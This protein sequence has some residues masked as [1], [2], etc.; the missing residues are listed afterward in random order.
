MVSS[1]KQLMSEERANMFR[2]MATGASKLGNFYVADIYITTCLKASRG[3]KPFPVIASLVKLFYLK[4]ACAEGV[5][6][7]ANKFC[8]ALKFIASKRDEESIAHVP[9]NL[10]R[11]RLLEGHILHDLALLAAYAFLLFIHAHSP[12]TLLTLYCI[13]KKRI[14]FNFDTYFAS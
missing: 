6:D 5:E 10:C 3:K 11:F 1:L 2:Q 9:A 13:H 8:K 14:L 12:R 7:R 4:A